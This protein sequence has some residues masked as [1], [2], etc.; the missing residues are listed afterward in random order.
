MSTVA[1]IV[2]TL[3]AGLAVYWTAEL[4][5]GDKVFDESTFAN[6]DDVRTDHLHLDIRLN[7]NKSRIEGANRIFM[8]TRRFLVG[9]VVLDVRGLDIYEV[10]SGEGEKLPWKVRDPNPNL[11]QAL[12]IKIPRIF[13][14]NTK[15]ELIVSY[16]TNNGSTAL[17]WLTP[18]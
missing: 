3:A 4:H 7:F 12:H 1:W 8:H 9:E 10:Y 11:G 15:F 2:A 16:A 5:A 6:L 18:E 13:W 14:P 17:T